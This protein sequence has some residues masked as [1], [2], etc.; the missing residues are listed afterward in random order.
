[1]SRLSYGPAM[2]G[3]QPVRR[4]ALPILASSNTAHFPAMDSIRGPTLRRLCNT[5]AASASGARRFFTNF[6]TCARLFAPQRM[7]VHLVLGLTALRCLRMPGY[8]HE[9]PRHD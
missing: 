7:A 3:Q 2:R 4:A 6:G 9:S 1:M 5:T 8:A